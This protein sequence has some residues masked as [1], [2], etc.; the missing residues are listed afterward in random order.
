[1]KLTTTLLLTILLFFSGQGQCNE[2]IEIN[3]LVVFGDSLS[4]QGKAYDKFYNTIPVSPPYWKGRFSNGPIW[5]DILAEKYAIVNEAEASSTAVDYTQF[6]DAPNYLIVNTL[7]HEINQFLEKSTFTSRDVVIIWIGGNDYATYDWLE[8]NDIERV[9]QEIAI[10][11]QRIENLGAR[12]I[13]VVNLP[14]MGIAPIARK[15]GVQQKLSEVS[16]NHNFRLQELFD[17]TFDPA[18]V[19][20]YDAFGAFNSIVNS[21][22]TYG[23][24]NFQDACYTSFF[25]G[26]GSRTNSLSNKPPAAS[27]FLLSMKSTLNPPPRHLQRWWS[28]ETPKCEGY[29]YMDIVHPTHATHKIIA[30]MLDEYIMLH[31]SSH[32]DE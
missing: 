20:V 3:R 30:T 11:T 4:D 21:P 25:W 2:N 5:I 8:P 6:S 10:Q 27:D 24:K 23:F 31:F 1:M 15:Q 17:Q 32:T 7:K 18:V 28:T 29:V 16:K 19:Q 26:V 12:H 13:L 22:H 9:V 14:D